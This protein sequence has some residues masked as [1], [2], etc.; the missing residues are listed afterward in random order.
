MT[1]LW[2]VKSAPTPPD[3]IKKASEVVDFANL[4]EEERQEAEAIEK[5]SATL[6]E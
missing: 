5:A 4:G 1:S 3:Y 2:V 6:R